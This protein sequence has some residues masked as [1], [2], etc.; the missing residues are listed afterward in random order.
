MCY[1]WYLLTIVCSLKLLRTGCYEMGGWLMDNRWKDAFAVRFW[2]VWNI[3]SLTEGSPEKV[4]DS[5]SLE[6]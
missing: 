4:W 1:L 3:P 5:W 2:T 6:S